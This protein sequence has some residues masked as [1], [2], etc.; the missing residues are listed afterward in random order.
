MYLSQDPIRLRGGFCLYNYTKN[1]NKYIDALGLS[2]DDL[3]KERER[4]NLPIAG[5]ENDK[6]TVA[7]LEIGDKSY[8][9]VNKGDQHP[10]TSM[11][12]E[13]INAITVTHAEADA[14]Q[15]AINAGEKGSAKTAILWVDRDPCPSC[16][17]NGGLRSLA[18]N[19]GVDELIV[20]SPSE[21]RKYT[22][23]C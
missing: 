14:V 20:H 2:F 7:K 23:T 16:G 19:L 6:S 17:K 3:A 11:T 12:L 21:T 22:P 10:K 5:S 8:Y 18:R 13:K 1:T 4:R 9:G 15:Q